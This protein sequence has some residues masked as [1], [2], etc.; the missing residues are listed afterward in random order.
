[1]L[2]TKK[3]N[4]ATGSKAFNLINK[5]NEKIEKKGL[6][7]KHPASIII[8]PIVVVNNNLKKGQYF[9]IDIKK[10]GILLCQDEEAE[11]LK[12]PKK[13]MLP[14]ISFSLKFRC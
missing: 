2:I 14:D 10:E 1:M 7:K 11:D 6:D 12:D 8:E 5:I 3:H 13:L 4:V 9:F